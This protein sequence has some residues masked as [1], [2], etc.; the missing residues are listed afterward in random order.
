MYTAD[1]VRESEFDFALLL[2]I[3]AYDSITASEA[4]LH[5]TIGTGKIMEEHFRRG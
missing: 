2:Y 3:S 1:Q 5:F 4:M